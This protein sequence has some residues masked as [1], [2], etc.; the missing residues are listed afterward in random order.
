MTELQKTVY[1]VLQESPVPMQVK[2]I[3]AAVKATVP[4]LCDD[5]I[6]PC[7]Y[8]KRKH[9]LWQHKVAWALQYLKLK[10]LVESAARGYWAIRKEGSEEPPP[11]E[12]GNDNANDTSKDSSVV[13]RL[14]ETQFRSDSPVEFEEAIR[15]AFEL[16]GFEAQLI[17]GK[18][19][20]DVLL[21]ANIGQ[22]SFKVNVDGKTS[23]SGKI[24]DRQ[25]DWI[26]LRDHKRKNNAD[27]VVLVGVDFS[28]GNLEERAAEYD[29][30]LLKTEDLVRLVQAH[31]K[32]PFTLVELKDLFTGKGDR[33]FQLDDLLSQNLQRRTLLERFRV[34]IE[35]M[36]SLQDRLGYFTF[37]SLAGRERIEELEIEPEDIRHI[38]SLLSLPFINGVKEISENKYILTIGIKDISCIFRQLSSFLMASR[39]KEEILP[40]ASVAAK[41]Q[42]A[43]ATKLGSKYFRWYLKGHSVVATA[44]KDKPYEH[45]CPVNHF[46]SIARTVAEAFKAQNVVN[47][48]LIFS[49]LEGR[50]LSPGRPFKGKTEEYK[51]RMVLGVLELERLIQWTGS[52][53]PVEYKL[54]VPVSRIEEWVQTNLGQ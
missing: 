28:G 24:M 25:I 45:Y 44:R 2:D 32:F 43:P 51:I 1:R 37:D 11:V 42:E 39:Q 36:Q 9:P 54:N 34:I 13:K 48:D 21:T 4:Q 22:E 33:S 8:C 20:T 35:E 27:F 46:Q 53:S 12:T 19:D 15:D 47:T 18:G 30:F 16:M 7:P 52:K 10:K 6:F 38:I 50:N 23:K 41:E 14:R 31:S 5:S 29:V 40:G 49:M 3:Y 26:S 17:G